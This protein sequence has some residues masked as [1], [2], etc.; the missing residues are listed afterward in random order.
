[1]FTFTATVSDAL[2][3]QA[4][5]QLTL[6]VNPP[7][8]LNAANLPAGNQ[9]LAYPQQQLVASNGVP[10]YGN[11]TWVAAPGSSLPPGLSLNP[12]SGIIGGLPVTPGTFSFTVSVSDSVGATA[13]QTYSITV[14]AA[15]PGI[16]TSSL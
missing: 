4:S 8:A 1:A 12:L 14:I 3:V 10:P 7:L 13:S 9:N 11:W 15:G 5:Q 2:G 6:N 16:G